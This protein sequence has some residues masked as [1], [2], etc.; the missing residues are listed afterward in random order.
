[1]VANERS[2]LSISVTRNS[3]LRRRGAFIPET[4]ARAIHKVVPDLN[5]NVLT[6]ISAFLTTVA[7]FAS[8]RR[9]R[10][11]EISFHA[12]KKE[13]VILAFAQTLDVLDGALAREV[14]RVTPGKHGTRWGGLWDALNDRWGAAS[15]GISRIVAA[16]KRGDKYGEFVAK[17][18]TLTN[19][20]SSFFR[21]E[22][23]SKGEIFPESGRGFKDPLGFFGTHL[24]RTLLA[25]PATLYP[26]LKASILGRTITLQ[27]VTDTLST[28]ANVKT[29]LD[30]AKGGK[31]VELPDLKDKDA[32]KEAKEKLATMK[33]DATFRRNGLIFAVAG[34]TLGVIATN[35]LLHPKL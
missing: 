31:K 1:M 3:S 21:A 22:G 2:P 32:Y 35:K 4:T 16:N 8:E 29:T 11:G 19:P 15:M 28:V 20:L 12:S 34:T 6:A 23:E 9:N 17:T 18:A 7:S 14:N 5:P 10:N 27:D 30:R 26:N 13:G 25:I 24:G 33:T